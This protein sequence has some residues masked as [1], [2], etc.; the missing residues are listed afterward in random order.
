MKPSDLEQGHGGWARRNMSFRR[1]FIV[2]AA[3][4]WSHTPLQCRIIQPG[5]GGFPCPKEKNALQVLLLLWPLFWKHELSALPRSRDRRAAIHQPVLAACPEGSG[6]P[7][8]LGDKRGFHT[9][10]LQDVNLRVIMLHSDII[11]HS[12]VCGKMDSRP[13]IPAYTCRVQVGS[14]APHGDCLLFDPNL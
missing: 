6:C 3:W 9:I 1:T 11:E 13:P 12:S 8:A 5:V 2:G 4:L 10:L 7:H 14:N